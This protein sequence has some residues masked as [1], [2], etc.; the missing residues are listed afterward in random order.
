MNTIG[1][2]TKDKIIADLSEMLDTHLEDVNT[3]F[4][5]TDGALTLTMSAKLDVARDAGGVKIETRLSFTKQKIAERYE[6]T[7]NERQQ[8]LPGMG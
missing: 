8:D 3:A 5:E 1:P 7:V 4:M 6:S 2:K